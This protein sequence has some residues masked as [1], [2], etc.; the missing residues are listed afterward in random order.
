M[1]TFSLREPF[2]QLFRHLSH[3]FKLILNHA[4]QYFR[5]VF[6]QCRRDTDLPPKEILIKMRHRANALIN[7][8]NEALNHMRTHLTYHFIEMDEE[9]RVTMDDV[10][11]DVVRLFLEKGKLADLWTGAPAESFFELL[12]GEMRTLSPKLYRSLEIF[13]GYEL[14]LRGFFQSRIRQNLTRMIPDRAEPLPLDRLTPEYALEQLRS[15]QEQTVNEV[16]SSLMRFV[17]EPSQAAFAVVQEFID[18]VLRSKE[19]ESTWRSFY[20]AHR[21]KVWISEFEQSVKREAL[22]REWQDLTG[23]AYTAVLG[24]QA[25]GAKSI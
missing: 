25:A 10:K 2:C 12:A 4:L 17:N 16:E 14:S 19:A 5:R 23:R 8:R 11:L 7:A 24:M 6:E 22:Q 18:Q 9:L 3:W 20:S 15:M 21:E 1:F 13:D